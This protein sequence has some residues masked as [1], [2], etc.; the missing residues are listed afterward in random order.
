MTQ[1]TICSY[2]IYMAIRKSLRFFRLQV[3]MAI[4]FNLRLEKN[5]I[6]PVLSTVFAFN[7]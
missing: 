5:K 3:A 4:S 2:D 1:I 6:T 7:F